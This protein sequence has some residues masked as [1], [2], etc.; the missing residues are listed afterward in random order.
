MTSIFTKVYSAVLNK[1]QH[2][3]VNKLKM[4]FE[5]TLNVYDLKIT[6][7]NSKN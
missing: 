4:N 5:S 2:K 1:L 6:K 7:R 3:R